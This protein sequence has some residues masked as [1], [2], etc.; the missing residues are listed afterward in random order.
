MTTDTAT[1]VGSV[2]GAMEDAGS[3]GAEAALA[4]LRA[5]TAFPAGAAPAAMAEPPPMP[6]GL[7]VGMKEVTRPN[8]TKY[9]VRK[10]GI[11]DDV[12]VLRKA[13]EDGIAV[14]AYGPPGTGKTALIEAAYAEAGS[15][16]RLH[17]IQGTGD[18]DVMNFVGGFIQLPDGKYHWVDGPLPKAMEAGEALYVDEISLIDPKVLPTLYSVMDGRGELTIDQNPARGTV[19]AQ[20]GFYVVASC[21]PDA[22]GARMS[23]ALLSRFALQ[24][25]VTTDY[26]LAKILGVPHKVVGAALNL[27]KKHENNEISWS[28]Q[29]RELLDYVRMERAFGPEI[30]IRNLI[31][32]APERDRAQVADTLTAAFTK[33]MTELT[34]G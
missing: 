18:T 12:A 9:H 33:Q 32:I 19:T 21:N 1:L 14:L 2:L 5:R 13:R 22:P 30:A 6:A 29:L 15:A 23:E 26:N 8:G 11:H 27:N 16:Q 20:P 4:A 17:T 3:S 34:L 28:P 10:F 31:S 7:S 25:K 24:F